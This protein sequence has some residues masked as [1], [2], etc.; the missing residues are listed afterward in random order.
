MHIVTLPL[1]LGK[2]RVGDGGADYKCVPQLAEGSEGEGLK[3]SMPGRRKS[4]SA[5]AIGRRIYVF[6]GMC[7]GEE[8]PEGPPGRVWVFDTE[9]LRWESLDPENGQQTSFP[10]ARYD[11]GCTAAT[12]PLPRT[13]DGPE[14]GGTVVERMKADLGKLSSLVTGNATQEQIQEPHGTLFVHGGKVLER[15]GELSDTWAFD[16]IGKHW[17]KLPDS[18]LMGSNGSVQSTIAFMNDMLYLI[19]HPSPESG[20]LGSNI[21]TLKFTPE[22]TSASDVEAELHV[23]GASSPPSGT[24]SD[25]STQPTSQESHAWTTASFPTNPLTPGPR[26]RSGASFLPYTTGNG[27]HYLIYLMGQ[28]L[29]L[30]KTSEEPIYWSDIWVHQP[31]AASISAAGTKDAAREKL[32]LDS[33]QGSWA[34]AKVDAGEMGGE[35]E[36]AGE[37]KAHPGPRGWFAAAEVNGEGILVWGGR[38]ARG[39]V[40]GDGWIVGLK[41]P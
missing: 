5:V 17:Q 24:A 13:R 34:E 18:P 2:G 28:Q 25:P 36:G 32:G 6:G 31:A 29:A 20:D 8:V 27:R 19:T 11:A 21:H 33:G 9:T 1:P 3:S 23:A 40:E 15:T 22:M 14:R 16:I 7:P 35:V 38:N 41:G 12:Q 4:H 10:E 30:S 37:G 39:E 26:S